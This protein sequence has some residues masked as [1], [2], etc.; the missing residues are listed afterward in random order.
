M[1]L[2]QRLKS[3]LQRARQLSESYLASFRTPQEWT[4]QVHPGTNHA[5]WFA[6]H[7]AMADNYF[8]TVVSPA[9]AK[10]LDAFEAPFGMKSQPTANPADYPPPEEVLA[11]MRDRRAALLAALEE[12]SDERLAEKLPQPSQLFTDLASVFELAIWHEGLHA[13]QIS[14]VRRSLGH[15]PVM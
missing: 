14:L 10:K 6:G 4:H 11:A 3:Q 13:G 9:R 12:L 15:S 5:L 2:A 8:L 1:P 7:M